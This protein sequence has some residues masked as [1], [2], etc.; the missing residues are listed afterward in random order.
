MA[1]LL[2]SPWCLPPL[3]HQILSHCS[4]ERTFDTLIGDDCPPNTPWRLGDELTVDERA[5]RDAAEAAYR[6]ALDDIHRE[7]QEET[8]VLPGK[9]TRVNQPE[10]FLSSYFGKDS[11]SGDENIF[12]QKL[13]FFNMFYNFFEFDK[14]LFSIQKTWQLKWKNNFRKQNRLKRIF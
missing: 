2:R 10:F 8:L 3:K 11:F 13:C 9:S 1:L 7:R 12:L 14:F 6:K 4:N 5:A